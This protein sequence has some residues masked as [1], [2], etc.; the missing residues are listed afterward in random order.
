GC[1]RRAK[2]HWE[3][4]LDCTW[5]GSRSSGDRRGNS[6]SKRTGKSQ[7]EREP[8]FATGKSALRDTLSRPA[9]RARPK[10]PRGEQSGFDCIE[11]QAIGRIAGRECRPLEQDLLLNGSLPV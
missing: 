3:Q 10:E 7:V 11:Q 9:A 2:R 5:C 4:T 8:G 1:H 6:S